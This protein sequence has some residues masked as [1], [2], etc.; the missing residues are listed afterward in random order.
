V[1]IL[2]GWGVD[3]EQLRGERKPWGAGSPALFFVAS[4]LGEDLGKTTEKKRWDPV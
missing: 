4:R 1:I 2:E 3:F